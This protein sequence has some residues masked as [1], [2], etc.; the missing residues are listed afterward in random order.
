MEFRY[1]CGNPDHSGALEEAGVI[2]ADAIIIGPADDLSD[3]EVR[4]LLLYHTCILSVKSH[5]TP[6]AI[7][8][9][10]GQSICSVTQLLSTQVKSSR[11]VCTVCIRQVFTLCLAVLTVQNQMLLAVLSVPPLVGLLLL[12]HL[13]AM[14]GRLVAMFAG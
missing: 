1:L 11:G 4:R 5:C 3:N 10:P 9:A 2:E 13:S 8:L 7:L 12:S 6:Y 14:K